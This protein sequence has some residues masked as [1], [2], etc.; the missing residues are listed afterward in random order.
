MKRYNI[1]D[2]ESLLQQP[3]SDF[4]Y[5]RRTALFA[6]DLLFLSFILLMEVDL[7]CLYHFFLHLHLWWLVF[8]FVTQLEVDYYRLLPKAERFN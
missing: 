1:S 2:G 7:F 5:R 3:I 6:Y 4:T 8:D